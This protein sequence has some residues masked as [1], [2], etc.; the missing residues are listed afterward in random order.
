MHAYDALGQLGGKDT[1]IM[2]GDWSKLPGWLFPHVPGF[3]TA[4]SPWLTLPPP[5]STA[6]VAQT[7]ATGVS[8]RLSQKDDNP[9]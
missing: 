8:Q 3:Q 7:S 5:G 2:L 4:F 1:T 6:P 9:Y